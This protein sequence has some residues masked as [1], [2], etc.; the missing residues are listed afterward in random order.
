VITGN[1]SYQDIGLKLEFESQVYAGNEIGIKIA[2]EVSNIV[3]E[4]T[5]QQG[6]RSYQI[7]TRNANTNLRLK[8]GETQI[9]GGL[10]T[11]QDR[12][13]ASKIPGLGHLPVVGRIFGNNDGAATRSE[14][15]L[16]ITPRIV[17]NLAVQ[18]P[19]TRNIFSGT[20]NVLREKPILAEPIVQSRGST[21]SMV[22]PGGTSTMTNNL[23]G[24][25]TPAQPV[26]NA[27]PPGAVLFNAQPAPSTPQAPPVE[28]G[29]LLPTP[30]AMYVRPPPSR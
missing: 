29:A 27:P 15:V 24:A 14:I 16:A 13:T 5:D 2:L 7:G 26:G 28:S 18:T 6:S 20:Y 12:N 8:D 1:V 3:A 19:D 17:R 30:P 21:G 4:F 22:T 11:D 10:I 23:P 25:V 9:L